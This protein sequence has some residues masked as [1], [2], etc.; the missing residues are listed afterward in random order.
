M[1]DQTP[2][3]PFN[4]APAKR[5]RNFYRVYRVMRLGPMGMV[6]PGVHPGPDA[7]ATKESAEA[8]GQWIV[9]TINWPNRCV[10]EYAGAF[11]EGERAN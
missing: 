10:M 5:W 11:P 6:F 2:A 7:F 8:H 3:H 9:R 4:A 1:P